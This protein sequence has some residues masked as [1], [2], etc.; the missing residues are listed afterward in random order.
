[1]RQCRKPTSIRRMLVTAHSYIIYTSREECSE[2]N[3]KSNENQPNADLPDV[4]LERVQP[5]QAP[6]LVGPPKQQPAYSAGEENLEQSNPF[7][8]PFL[9]QGSRSQA[10]EDQAMDQSAQSPVLV[11]GAPVPAVSWTPDQPRLAPYVAPV[12]IYQHASGPQQNPG[13]LP[14]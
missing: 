7:V 14:H 12:D 5:G 8:A 4:S 1:M 11:Q 2:S 10:T 3:E 13:M 6:L 9:T